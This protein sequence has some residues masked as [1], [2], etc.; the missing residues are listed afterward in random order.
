MEEGKGGKGETNRKLR[1][2]KNL[3]AKWTIWGCALMADK[4][5]TGEGFLSLR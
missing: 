2:E 3:V 1:R 4:E 5:D